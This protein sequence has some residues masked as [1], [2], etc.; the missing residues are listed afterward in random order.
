MQCADDR[1][2]MFNSSCYLFVSYPEVT[3][4]TA[5]QICK[6]MRA[7]LASVQSP[8]EERFVTSNIRRTAEYRTSAVYWLGSRMSPE[9]GTYQWL[10]GTTMSYTA[11]LPGQNPTEQNHSQQQ[12]QQRELLVKYETPMCLGIQWT[13]SPTPMLPS[14]LYWRSKR[15]SAVG[16]YVCKRRNQISGSELNFNRT[17]NGTEGRLTSPNYPGNYYSNLDFLVKIIGP[18]R[19]RLIIQFSKLDLEPQLECLYDY[20]EL[21]SV[22]RG[23]ADALNDAMKWCGNH[24]TDMERFDFVS[25]TNEAELQFH[26][27]YSISGSGFSV[28]WHAVDVSSC[29]LQTL[30]AREGVVTSP[31]YPHF[32]LARLDC[33]ITILAPAGKRIWLEI[34]DYDMDGSGWYELGQTQPMDQARASE[35]VLEL[36]LGGSSTVFRPFQVSGQL[37]DGAFVSTGERLQVR[38]RTADR[39]LGAGFRAQYK[40]VNGIQEERIIDLGNV[41]SGSLLHLNYPNPPPTHIDFLQHLIAPLGHI[42]L[43]ELYNMK[44][45]EHGCRRNEASIDVLDNYA[46]SNGTSWH[47]CYSGAAGDES[48]EADGSVLVA[49]AAPLAIT[50]Y[51]N[52]LHVRQRS[53]TLGIPLNGSVRVR[54]DVNYKIKLL[55][56]EESVVESCS[57]NPCQNMGKCMT[58]GGRKFCQCV[59]HFTGI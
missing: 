1:L 31:N 24:D 26:S 38:L 25:E 39:P 48:I 30:T 21:R 14:G 54:T 27:D 56:Q 44:F 33:A 15:C 9:N 17:V 7:H 46:D 4:S 12:Q 32:L 34:T 47:L 52:T 42:I 36:D 2:V 59:G 55:R 43:L 6:G 37:T 5:Q 53:R 29:P 3:W 10:D 8:E 40:T 57:P 11:W 51:L 16:G 28:T 35:A 23:N 50:S 45:S 49:S 58:N 20:I 22:I 13:S 19:T 18:E 41:S